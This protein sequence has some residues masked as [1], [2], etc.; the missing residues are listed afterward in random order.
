MGKLVVLNEKGDITVEWDAD[1]AES[2]K[3]AKDE[4]ARLKKDGYEFFE[5]VETKGKRV[6]RFSKNLGKVIASPGVKK[7]EDKK[8]GKRGKA[9]GGGPNARLV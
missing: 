7:P 2:V 5:A 4:F 1:D 6:T 3:K 8:T 9:M